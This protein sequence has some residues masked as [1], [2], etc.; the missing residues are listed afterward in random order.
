VIVEVGK[1]G[2]NTIIK[3]HD[4]MSKILKHQSVLLC[5]IVLCFHFSYSQNNKTFISHWPTENWSVSTP[6]EQGVNSDKLLKMFEFIRS[7]PTLDFHSIIIV[8]H[9]HIITE[10]YWAPY[11]KNITHN[12]KSASKS[13]I[14][15]LVG[16]ALE[17]NYLKNIEQKVSEF[18]PEYTNDSLKRNI[19][20]HDLLTMSAGFDW[21]EDAGPSAFDLMSWNKVP[22]KYKPGETFEYNSA[23]THMMS[24]ILTKACGEN[25]K[26]FADTWIFKPLGIKDYQWS[27]S[28]NGIYHG[29]SDIFLTPRDMAKF[30]LLFLNNGIWNEKSIIPKKWIK[31][32]TSMQ[33]DIPKNVGYAAGLKYGY[34]WWIQEKAYMAWGA[35][36]QYIIVNPDLDLVVV[37]TADGFDNINLYDKFMK[38]F[39]EKYIYSAVTR[40]T[41]VPPQPMVIKELNH[42]AQ[43]LEHPPKTSAKKMP[44]IAASI[45]SATYL[46]EKNEIGFQSTSFLFSESTCNWEYRI[47][48]QNVKLKVGLNGNYLNN[49]I[50]VSMGVNP[51]GD[52][53]ACKG[54]WDGNKFIITHHIIGDPSKQ[55]FTFDFSDNKINMNLI[56]R[57]MNA[58]IN[59]SKEK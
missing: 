56:T 19:S 18:Y 12:I 16:I 46:F 47:G 36:G 3:V 9:S 48:D 41:N 2:T 59:G 42:I 24:A 5:A 14:S 29:G 20:L 40:N 50:A 26:D 52:K 53:I 30:G 35:G 57:G 45:S 21:K 22:M 31:E 25:T 23:L 43:E 7:S 37:F 27:K 8:R 34:W 15:A 39:L 32:S 38:Q 13:I 28:K 33:V 51:N 49:D 44:T 10:A 58:A 4:I 11:N 54:Y 1:Y 17:K 6:E 55:I